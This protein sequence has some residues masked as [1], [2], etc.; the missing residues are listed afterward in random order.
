MHKPHPTGFET[1]VIS[2]E[3]YNLL[4]EWMYSSTI[5]DL[6]T[7]KRQVINFMPLLLYLQGKSPCY[8][9]DRGLGGFKPS[10]TTVGKRTLLPLLEMK[11]WPSRLWTVTIS[12]EL[13]QHFENYWELLIFTCCAYEFNARALRWR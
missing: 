13:S 9:L 12:S 2:G 1:G 3:R 8:S 5:L 4:G 6:G 10:L 11:S 7:R